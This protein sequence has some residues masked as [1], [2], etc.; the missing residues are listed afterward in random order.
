MAEKSVKIL[1]TQSVLLELI[2][3]AMG[4][5]GDER[6]RGLTVTEVVCSRG[7]SDATVYV[8]SDEYSEAEWP[9]LLSQLKK[10]S[11]FIGRYCLAAEGWFKM[12][13]LTFR[14]DDSFEKRLKMEALLS[15]ITKKD[16]A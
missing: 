14:F 12:P 8:Y 10:S 15:Q 6:L 11:G 5:L 1:Q 3:E 13:N 7:K 2:S 4:Q 9:K 16:D